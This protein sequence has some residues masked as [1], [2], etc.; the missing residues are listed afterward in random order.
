MLQTVFN[1]CD[2][3]CGCSECEMHEANVDIVFRDDT[4]PFNVDVMTVKGY[5]CNR[6]G[7]YNTNFG[8]KGQPVLID[9]VIVGDLAK[10]HIEIER[11][12]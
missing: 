5:K 9:D 1:K 7:Q 2:K 12:Y 8:F 6:Y 3:V 4:N 10:K 11:K